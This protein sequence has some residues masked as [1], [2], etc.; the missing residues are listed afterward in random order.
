MPE[1]CDKLKFYV[2]NNK[3]QI[4]KIKVDRT[5]KKVKSPMTEVRF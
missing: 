5:I 3:P 1:R 2:L 4:F